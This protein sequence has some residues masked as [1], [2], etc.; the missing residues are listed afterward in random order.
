MG[1]GDWKEWV[2][3]HLPSMQLLKYPMCHI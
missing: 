1:H 2:S 3:M